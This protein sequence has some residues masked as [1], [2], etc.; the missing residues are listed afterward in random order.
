MVGKLRVLAFIIGAGLLVDP[1]HIYKTKYTAREIFERQQHAIETIFRD[2]PA[3]KKKRREELKEGLRRL[4]KKNATTEEF[5]MFDKRF[6][7]ESIEQGYRKEAAEKLE[8][9]Y[10]PDKD[11][12][13]FARIKEAFLN[14]KSIIGSF[15]VLYGLFGRR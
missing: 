6:M 9:M 7:M 13:L 2:K 14:I 15:L 8:M 11:C 4:N 12:S 5:C 3:Q 1:V 10:N